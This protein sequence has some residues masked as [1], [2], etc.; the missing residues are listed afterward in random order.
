M[1]LLTLKPIFEWSHT[2]CLL[3]KNQLILIYSS[4]KIKQILKDIMKKRIFT[5]NYWKINY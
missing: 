5:I 3:L 4:F 1:I 2:L